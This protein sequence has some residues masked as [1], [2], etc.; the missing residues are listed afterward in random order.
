MRIRPFRFF[1]R[2]TRDNPHDFTVALII[3]I[4]SAIG[5]FLMMEFVPNSGMLQIKP[6]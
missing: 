1:T 6:S 4:V 2:W 5:V 3:I